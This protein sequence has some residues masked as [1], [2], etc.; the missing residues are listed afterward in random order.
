MYSRRPS[1][2]TL[3]NPMF[4]RITTLRT[5]LRRPYSCP[6]NTRSVSKLRKTIFNISRPRVRLGAVSL[7]VLLHAKYNA[8]MR[9][10]SCWCNSFCTELSLVRN[11]TAPFP[12]LRYSVITST[13]GKIVLGSKWCLSY[14][15]TLWK[16]GDGRHV[17]VE[18]NRFTTRPLLLATAA[19]F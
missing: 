18:I 15:P 1:P 7:M 6:T 3:R 9:L 5:M 2:P 19:H 12:L 17:D 14:F 10:L 13:V 8:G 11:M 16:I 4:Q